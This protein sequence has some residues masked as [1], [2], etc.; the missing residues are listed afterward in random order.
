[1]SPHFGSQKVCKATNK[2]CQHPARCA[3]YIGCMP[4][5]LIGVP[6]PG[7]PHLNIAEELA[8]QNEPKHT[9]ERYHDAV[10]KPSHYTS[11]SIECIDAMEASMTPEEFRGYLKGAIFKYNWRMGRKDSRAQ[12]AGKLRW[13]ASRLEAF[14]KKHG[15]DKVLCSGLK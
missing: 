7:Y 2:T 12:E 6:E 1:M 11:G 10:E 14:E 5:A 13:Y 3:P 9:N 4:G 8:R 15:Q